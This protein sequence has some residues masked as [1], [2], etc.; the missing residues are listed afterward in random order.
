MRNLIAVIILAL[1]FCTT[2]EAKRKPTT[3]QK[4]KQTIYK[5]FHPLGQYRNALCIAYAESRF[6]PR[7]RHVNSDGTTDLGTFQV[8]TYWHPYF[9]PKRLLEIRYN[10]AAAR[11]IYLNIDKHGKTHP[12]WGPWATRRSC[13]V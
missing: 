4:V 2:A 6:K 12:S 3:Q 5:Y 13:G 9:N 8:N 10:I 11:K 7:A 1:V